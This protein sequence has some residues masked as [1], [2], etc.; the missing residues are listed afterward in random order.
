MDKQTIR[1]YTDSDIYKGWENFDPNNYLGYKSWVRSGNYVKIG[2][3]RYKEMELEL[4]FKKINESKFEK[5]KKIVLEMFKEITQDVENIFEKKFLKTAIISHIG[6]HTK[7]AR[8]V[9][10]DIVDLI[11]SKKVR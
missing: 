5:N 2:K 10:S 9:V 4:L 3:I 11:F 8:N 1:Y 6:Y 7:I